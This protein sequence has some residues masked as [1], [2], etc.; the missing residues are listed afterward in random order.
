M[1]TVVAIDVPADLSP[2]VT[3]GAVTGCRNALGSERCIASEAEHA[4]NPDWYAIIRSDAVEQGRLRIEFRKSASSGELVAQRIL[5]F[6][7]RDPENSRWVSAG[8]VVAALVAAEDAAEKPSPIGVPPARDRAPLAPGRHELGSGIDAGALLGP[9]LLQGPYR[10]GGFGRGWIGSRSSG[11]IG[12]LTLRYAERGG[13]PT[14]TWWSISGGVGARLG[15]WQSVMT[16]DVLGELVAE[17][18]SASASD[19][20]SGRDDHGAQGRFGGRLGANVAAR[21]GPGFRLL[22]GVDATALTPAVDVQVKGATVGREPAVRFAFTAGAR[23]D[24]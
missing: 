11:V 20:T 16:V 15:V 12:A 18:M 13:T 14:L 10:I 23:V 8:L 5:S 4:V 17:R 22:T 3:R 9:A 6:S 19:P 21:L 24:F 1:A 7:E 2:V